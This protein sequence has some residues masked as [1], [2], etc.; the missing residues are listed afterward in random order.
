MSV[1]QWH[2]WDCT[3]QSNFTYFFS[4]WLFFGD[5]LE[6]QAL[7]ATFL[8]HFLIWPSRWWNEVGRNLLLKFHDHQLYTF[9]L[10]VMWK[11]DFDLLCAPFPQWCTENFLWFGF[12]WSPCW[13]RNRWWGS[14]TGFWCQYT[15]S[16]CKISP[17]GHSSN[18]GLCF[19]GISPPQIERIKKPGSPNSKTYLTSGFGICKPLP[20]GNPV[21]TER[22]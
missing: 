22:V 3:V 9:V 13:T 1:C 10:Y 2:F 11:I 8:H 5:R 16:N 19:C 18:S 20:A 12:L 21:C 6:E 14:V 7:E 17:A 15:G 4:S